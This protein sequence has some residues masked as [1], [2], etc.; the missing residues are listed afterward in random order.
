MK[1][2]IFYGI[3]FTNGV[4]TLILWLYLKK[5]FRAEKSEATTEAFTCR[6]IHQYRDMKQ[7]TNSTRNEKRTSTPKQFFAAKLVNAHFDDYTFVQNPVIKDTGKQTE[8]ENVIL[9]LVMSD[10]NV[11]S[12]S[13]RTVLRDAIG[14]VSIVKKWRLKI[15]FLIGTNPTE[16]SNMMRVKEESRQ[17]GDIILGD[18]P[19][20]YLSFTI[21]TAMAYRWVLQYYAKVKYILRI[22]QD[23]IINPYNLVNLVESIKTKNPEKDSI[24]MGLVITGA[25]PTFNHPRWAYKSTIP[26]PPGVPYP[27]YPAGPAVLSSIAAT[28]AINTAICDTPVIFPDDCYLGIIAEKTEINPIGLEH[29]LWSQGELF[30]TINEKIRR[31]KVAIHCRGS[32]DIMAKAWKYIQ[33]INR[34]N[35]N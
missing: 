12:K 13:F 34:T 35:K 7:S 25:K 20:D 4:L 31:R 3:I 2:P 9:V 14:N 10:S 23:V 19:D 29:F 17:F 1:L 33:K 21:K 18:F 11:V 30:L 28:M 5:H 15:L 16:S 27:P 8:S 32:P 26:W 22:T 24:I 6:S